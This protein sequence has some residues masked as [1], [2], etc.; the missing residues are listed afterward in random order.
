MGVSIIGHE[1]EAMRLFVSI[2][3]RWK[4]TGNIGVSASSP[5]RKPGS[6]R[7]GVRELRNLVSSINYDARRGGV[8]HKVGTERGLIVYQ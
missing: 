6:V 1:E 8:G 7:K 3:S 4:A 2:E 5:K